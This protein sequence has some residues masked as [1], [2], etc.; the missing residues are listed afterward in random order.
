MPPCAKKGCAVAILAVGGVCAVAG[1]ALLVGSP[2]LVGLV[3][4]SQLA[5]YPGSGSYADFVNLPFPIVTSIYIFNLTN[6][7]A[8]LTNGSKP[9]VVELGPYV[10][11]ERHAR[12]GIRF[13]DNA[14]V[15]YRQVRTYH[16]RPDLSKGSLDDQVVTINPVAATVNSMAADTFYIVRT[17]I[18]AMMKDLKE[19]LMVKTS[20]RKLLF[21]GYEDPLLENPP[22]WMKKEDTPKK[23]GYYY[24][25]N[26]SDRVDGVFNMYTGRSNLSR[27]GSIA[28]WNYADRLPYYEGRCGEVRGGGD[29]LPPGR[30]KTY[31]E[32]FSNDLC[33]PL[34]MDYESSQVDR[35]LG[36]YAY[37]VTDRF[38]AN[39]SENGD[40]WCF[41]PDRL[42]L[43][44]GVFDIGPCRRDAPIL[45]S[46]P[47]FY[48][49]DPFFAR[50]VATALA[51]EKLKHETRFLVEPTS[52]VPT[53]LAARF[54]VNFLLRRV[55][56][57]CFLFTAPALVGAV[58]RQKLARHSL[59]HME[60]VR[61]FRDIR[62]SL[63]VPAMWFESGVELPPGTLENLR[64]LAS[65]EDVFR[66]C[67]GVLVLLAI[68]LVAAS[69]LAAALRCW[70]RSATSD[71]EEEGRTEKICSREKWFGMCQKIGRQ[72]QKKP[73]C[74]LKSQSKIRRL[75]EEARNDIKLLTQSNPFESCLILWSNRAILC[76]II[77]L[78]PLPQGFGFASLLSSPSF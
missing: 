46:Q 23:F 7:D 13:N 37:T 44:S 66:A 53:R 20:V 24:Q 55:E 48:Q 31:I 71:E 38:F 34:R 77:N 12:T 16:F 32:I 40:N 63:L 11:D 57:V 17:K 33:R 74:L 69:T 49:A 35:G 19:Q 67:G 3:E 58:V 8:V 45:M 27:M 73:S 6:A 75:G 42:D 65:L 72:R 25:R 29:T 39:K 70:T 28:R 9:E 4:K 18:D 47:H 52:G 10:Y 26:G 15:T 5:L 64:V 22:V 30:D 62:E 41:D 60:Q 51:P 76:A 68:L 14:T 50:Q 43:P 54:Q 78:P 59:T 56:Q 1:L 2:G 36:V 61:L 21:D